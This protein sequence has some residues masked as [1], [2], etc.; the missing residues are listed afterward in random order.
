MP[1][2]L[3][4][5]VRHVHP[6][7]VSMGKTPSLPRQGVPKHNA[8]SKLGNGGRGCMG[9]PKENYEHV[10]GWV[11]GFR[12]VI[13]RRKD[14]REDLLYLWQ[15]MLQVLKICSEHPLSTTSL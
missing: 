4:Y 12:M 7:G 8:M 10:L 3:E 13:G 1:E 5:D 15:V 6:Q 2:A 11:E 9:D 14:R